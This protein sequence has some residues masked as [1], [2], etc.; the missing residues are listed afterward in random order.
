VLRETDPQTTIWELLLPEE[1]KRL[2]AELQAVDAYLDDERFI[3]PWRALF[4]VRLGRPSVP[5]DTLL[6]LLYLKHRYGLGYESLCR[7]VADSISWRRFCRIGLDRPVPH[8]TTLIKLVR[9]AGPQVIEELNAALVAKLAAGKLL[10]GR[11]LRVDTTV[12]EADIDYPTDADLL[13]HAVRKLGGLVRRIKARGAA[14]RTRFRDRGRAAGRRMK[15]LARTLRRRTGVA[16]AEVDRLTGEV[17][18]IARRSLQQ[19]QAVAR[20]A[21]GGLARRPGDGRLGRLVGELAETITATERLLAQTDQ[22]LAGNRVIPDRLVS[23]AD[24]DARPIRKGKPQHPTQF[25]YTLLVAECERGFIADHRLQRGNPPDAPQLVPVVERV[26]AVTGR[27]P[28]TVVGD[29]GFG[30]AAN[31]QAVEALGVKH[32][33]LQRNGTP[34]TAR[35][36]VERTRA[37]RRLR[38]WRVG[39][40]ARISHLK[41]SFGLRRTRLRRLGGARTWVGLGIFAYNLQRMTVVAR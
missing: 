5:I 25:G 8:P 2:P 40:E 1:A 11:K 3:A 6:R 24:P 41:R 37:F 35:R 23:L 13:E 7:E 29:R 33:G 36:A 10:R 9:R 32:V 16:M 19:V 31:D 15:Q 20:N 30:T 28:G 34:G 4:S 12:V 17:A 22:R 26:I 39:I 14:S 27:L 38:N 18:Q 21:R